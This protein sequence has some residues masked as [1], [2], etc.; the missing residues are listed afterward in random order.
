MEKDYSRANLHEDQRALLEPVG[1]LFTQHLPMS[2][3]A[4]R[5]FMGR[6]V[7]RWQEDHHRTLSEI[8][9]AP[10]AEKHKVLDEIMNGYLVDIMTKIVV[11]PEQVPLL[12]EAISKVCKIVIAQF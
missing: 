9:T 8:H 5:G 1:K 10:T 11:K 3:L 6:A 4:I 2:E 12:K 7:G